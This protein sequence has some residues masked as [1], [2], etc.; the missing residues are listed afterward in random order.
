MN[1]MAPGPSRKRAKAEADRTP[2]RGPEHERLRAFLGRWHA[3]GQ[4]YGAGQ[5]QADP[6]GSVE[7]W[8]SDETCE[9]L[10]GEFFIVQTWDAMTGANAFKGLAIIGYDPETATYVTRSFENHGFFRE[11]VT[12]IEGNV[13]TFT[14]DTERA[15]VEFSDNGDT[16]EIK[17]EWRPDGKTWLPLCDRKAVRVG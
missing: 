13:W 12:R 4:S 8:V 5:S 15:R 9:W 11:Y 2:K 3:E 16:Q 10:P 14:G 1:E 6:R 17:W 7:R